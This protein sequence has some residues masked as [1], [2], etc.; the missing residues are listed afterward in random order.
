M[1]YSSRMQ[2][3]GNS[4]TI[5][6]KPGVYLF[7]DKR[8]V[9]I[10]V[11]KAKS[12]QKRVNSY[13]TKSPDIKTSVLLECLY[14]IDYI[15]TD[16]EMNALLLERELIKQYKPRYNIALRD[17]KSYPLLKLTTN[18]KW[19]R[20]IIVRE[21][22]KDGAKYFGRLQGGMIK[23][24]L[25]LAKKLFPLRWCKETP[26][27]MREQ[28]CLYYRIGNCA[29]PCIG[30]INRDDYLS[31]IFGVSLFLQGKM[32]QAIKKL[33]QEMK[34]ASQNQDF[35]K[36]GLLRDRIKILNRMKEAKSL[37]RAPE[38]KTFRDLLGLKAV[39]GLKKLPLRIECFDISNISGTNMVA[40]M[41]TFYAG[42]PQKSD[43]RRFKIRSLGSRPNDVAAIY[44]VVKRRYTKTLAQKMP[45]P[46]LVI[47]DGGLGQ[48][49]A[50][51]KALAEAGLLSLP[52]IGLAKKQ[53]EVYAPGR[54]KTLKLAKTTKTLQ[55]LQRIRDEAHRFAITYHR[56]QRQKTLYT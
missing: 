2:V 13:F 39:L 54:S 12:L 29:G 17:D 19:P 4:K 44:E 46:D 41:V 18:E 37:S 45:L 43:Y 3:N 36:A 16:S 53:E 25:R 14:K 7:K 49:N 33:E 9:V 8:G 11:G 55:L 22:K 24:V 30:K 6:N 20:L 40:S 48:V 10:Y 47:V 35:E 15:L 23:E 27:R 51:K 21:K 42:L 28:P 1:V 5:P 56:K 26:L 31:L 34:K 50:A 38:Q 32:R 52:I